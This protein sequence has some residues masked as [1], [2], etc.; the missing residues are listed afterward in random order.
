VIETYDKSIAINA[1]DGSDAKTAP[2]KLSPRVIADKSW[3]GGGG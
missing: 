2:Q 1:N 3:D